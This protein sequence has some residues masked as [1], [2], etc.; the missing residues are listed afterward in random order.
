[1]QTQTGQQ[2]TR[3]APGDAAPATT[4]VN[5]RKA[6]D[7][8]TGGQTAVAPAGEDGAIVLEAVLVEDMSIDGMCGVY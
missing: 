8:A 6:N 4:V 5:Q 1:M 3:S 2:K 7:G